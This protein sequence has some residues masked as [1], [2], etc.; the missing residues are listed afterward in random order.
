MA[1]NSLNKGSLN[2]FRHP[3]WSSIIY[4]NHIL[5]HF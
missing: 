2:L 4:E 5:T 3:K 1:C